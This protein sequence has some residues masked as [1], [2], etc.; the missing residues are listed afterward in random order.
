MLRAFTGPIKIGKLLSSNAVPCDSA[1]GEACMA[2]DAV[3][4][5][6]YAA[7]R[8]SGPVRGWL[9]A[10]AAIVVFIAVAAFW[11]IRHLRD[12]EIEAQLLATPPW[13][14]ALGPGLVRFAVEQAKPV[15]AARC[16]SCHG[17]D[18]KGNVAAGAPNL[19]DGS[20][21]YGDGS[22]YEIERTILFGVRSGNPKSRNIADMTG[23][24]LLGLLTDV[25]VRNVVQ[26]VRQISRQSH[27]AEAAVEGSKIFAGKGQ[28]YDCHGSDA[29]G[30]SDYGAPDLTANIWSYG[31]DPQSLYKSIYFGR[32]GICPSWLGILD[33][34]QVRALAVYIYAASHHET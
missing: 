7:R 17:A 3:S 13:D 23:F 20:W 16:A 9:W 5:A 24:G 25:E 6:R 32:H 15:F 26:F 29:R 33:L 28:C 8:V 4:D 14:I 21:L 19:S 22:V 1:L 10:I 12:S 27:Q 30:N 34:K 31:G 11:T 18:M 2:H